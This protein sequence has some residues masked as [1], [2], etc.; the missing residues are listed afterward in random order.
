MRVGQHFHWPVLNVFAVNVGS[1]T[2]VFVSS[3]FHLCSPV[4][5]DLLL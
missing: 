5:L 1:E 3:S 2:A 4:G